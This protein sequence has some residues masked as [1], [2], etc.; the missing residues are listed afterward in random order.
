MVAVSGWGCLTAGVGGEANPHLEGLAHVPGGHGVG[1][2]RRPCDCRLGVSEFLPFVA[3]FLGS[4]PTLSVA[5]RLRPVGPGSKRKTG[6]L[7]ASGGSWPHLAKTEVT[8]CRDLGR[9]Y[10]NLE[11]IVHHLTERMLL[12]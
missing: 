11:C 8:A 4:N 3:P 1:R 7:R 2:R 6:S 12:Q 5:I 10:G 9:E